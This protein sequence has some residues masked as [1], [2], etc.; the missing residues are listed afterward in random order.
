MVCEFLI[1]YIFLAQG[2]SLTRSR[3]PWNFWGSIRILH[4]FLFYFFHI[5]NDHIRLLYIFLLKRQKALLGARAKDSHFPVGCL[6]YANPVYLMIIKDSCSIMSETCV[7]G[8][9]SCSSSHSNNYIP[10][11]DHYLRQMSDGERSWEAF[12]LLSF[13]AYFSPSLLLPR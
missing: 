10:S 12:S 1:K 6:F 3:L 7:T 9:M 11:Q 4:H 5:A 2:N 8:H 13:A